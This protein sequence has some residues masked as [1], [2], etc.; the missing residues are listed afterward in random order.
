MRGRGNLLTEY[1]YH[2]GNRGSRNSYRERADL[3]PADSTPAGFYCRS[4]S[5]KLRT[6]CPL[7]RSPVSERPSPSSG[8]DGLWTD[9]QPA[10]QT[11]SPVA[12][13]EFALRSDASQTIGQVANSVDRAAVTAARSPQP[14]PARFQKGP[15]VQVHCRS[16]AFRVER[17]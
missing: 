9:R 15:P 12:M 13:R 3:K 4:D 8:F 14:A 16:L 10:P 1:G 11:A 5:V 17:W 2:F 7:R 6:D